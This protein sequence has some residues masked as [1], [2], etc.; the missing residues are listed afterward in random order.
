VP[1]LTPAAQSTVAV[2]PWVCFW[3]LRNLC[4]R[5]HITTDPLLAISQR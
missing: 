3:H 4:L 2:L 5:V 1:V